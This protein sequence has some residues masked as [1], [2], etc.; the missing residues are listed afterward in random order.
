M[1]V[2]DSFAYL[3]CRLSRLL[4]DRFAKITK[5]YPIQFSHSSD[6]PLS[7]KRDTIPD[8]SFDT[9]NHTPN[10][11]P[12]N[13]VRRIYISP[14]NPR[15]LN[16]PTPLHE[17]CQQNS[18]I[19]LKPFANITNFTNKNRMTA[20]SQLALHVWF[21][22]SHSWVRFRVCTYVHVLHIDATSLH[23]TLP[24]TLSYHSN[25]SLLLMACLGRLDVSVKKY[26]KARIHLSMC[27][28]HTDYCQMC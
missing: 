18:R 27:V 16:T 15:K 22:K 21:P 1:S 4:H 24:D 25:T 11:T 19:I 28:V 6:L 8:K 9:P 2:Y 3:Y 13:I 10:H 23:V 12:C 14:E 20:P 17:K 5:A 7:E 26:N